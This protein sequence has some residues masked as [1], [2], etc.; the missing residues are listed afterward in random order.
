MSASVASD[1]FRF[2]LSTTPLDVTTQKHLR[3]VYATLLRAVLLTSLT[4]AL[5]LL[6]PSLL[7]ISSFLSFLTFPALIFFNASPRYSRNRT[8]AFYAFSALIGLS[9]GPLLHYAVAL[10]PLIPV[11][12]FAGSA[13]VFA[14]LSVS[15]LF[16]RRRS[17]LALGSLLW[18]A[19]WGMTLINLVTWLVGG[20]FLRSIGGGLSLWGMLMVMCGFVLW[21]TQMIVER[22]S[23]GD[24]D[25][26]GLSMDLL[27]DFIAIVKRIMIIMMKNEQRRRE[28][29]RRKNRN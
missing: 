18:T 1:P 5:P 3:L 9:S 29:D 16:A 20:S 4:A 2:F 26:V 7:H 14:G 13:L 27:I 23:R 24:R 11:V 21:D 22:I 8:L 17:Y 19:L 28:Q 6:I 15:A 10:N 25:Y 12:A